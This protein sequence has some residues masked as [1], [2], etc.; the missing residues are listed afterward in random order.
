M[1]GGITLLDTDVLTFG[2]RR[3]CNPY[4][5]VCVF[6]KEIPNI[7]ECSLAVPSAISKRSRLEIAQTPV[8]RRC[9]KSVNMYEPQNKAA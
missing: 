9:V 4:D 2:N 1:E 7:Q 3:M 6:L 8:N 5:P